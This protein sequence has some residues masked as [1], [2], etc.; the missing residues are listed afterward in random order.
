MNNEESVLYWAART[1]SRFYS[2]RDGRHRERHVVYLHSYERPG[3]VLHVAQ[4]IRAINDLKVHSYG[5]GCRTIIMGG[6]AV[7]SSTSHL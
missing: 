3:F 2:G 6:G 1:I 7:S 5:T 4:N